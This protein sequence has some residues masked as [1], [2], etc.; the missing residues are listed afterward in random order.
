M[1]DQYRSSLTPKMIEALVR[2]QDWL[3]I[4]KNVITLEEHLTR[5]QN[6]IEGLYHFS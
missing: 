1:L 5:I 4:N 6:L 2:T 3:K